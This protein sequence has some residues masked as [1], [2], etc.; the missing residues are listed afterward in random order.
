MDQVDG[1]PFVVK[2]HRTYQV[3]G[4]GEGTHAHAIVG[5]TLDK[6]LCELFGNLEACRQFLLLLFLEIEPHHRRRNIDCEHN[7]DAIGVCFRGT[8]N[9]LGPRKGNDYTR[10]SG[11]T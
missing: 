3:G 11:K 6:F 7:I 5:T 9:A 8:Q 2:C 4:A 10:S 1:K